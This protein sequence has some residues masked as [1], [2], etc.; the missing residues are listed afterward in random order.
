MPVGDG[1]PLRTK[2]IVPDDVPAGKT[3]IGVSALVGDDIG[4][5]A[6]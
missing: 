6:E 3:S 5:F 2:H 4:E 1:A